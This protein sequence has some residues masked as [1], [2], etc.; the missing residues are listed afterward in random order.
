MPALFAY[1][2]AIGLLLGGGYGALSWLAAP[3]PV[4]VAARVKAKPPQRSE[5]AAETPSAVTS[6]NHADNDDQTAPD[7]AITASND[8]PL[9]APAVA[10]SQI[11]PAEA[12]TP[13]TPQQVRSAHA[14][15]PIEQ[16]S[17]AQ[18]AA[19]LPPPAVT[20]PPRTA[21]KLAASALSASRVKTIKRSQVRQASRQPE[22]PA[23]KRRLALMILRTVQY[24][25][26]RRV[27]QLLPYR[28]GGRALAFAPDE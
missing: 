11:P 7:K 14:E 26:G 13:A 2:I 17:R 25:D 18:P 28:G 1:V 16:Q 23:A 10:A 9:S 20:P 6:P 27:S 12:S 4:K 5:A 21:P 15:A 19:P 3:E 22:R 24:P 8:Q